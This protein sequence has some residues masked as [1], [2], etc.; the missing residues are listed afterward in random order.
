LPDRTA[1]NF[2]GDNF[3]QT[4][5]PG[6]FGGDYFRGD[7]FGQ[8]RPSDYFGGNKFC[9]TGPLTTSEVDNFGRT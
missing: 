3:G 6:N 5:P 7:N 2:G 8:T 9:R 1:E 4:R